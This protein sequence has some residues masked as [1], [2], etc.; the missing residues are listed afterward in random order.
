M[1]YLD[2]PKKSESGPGFKDLAFVTSNSK[3]I[4]Q[5]EKIQN[6]LQ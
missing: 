4:Q 6:I 3:F 2:G 1:S 5:K